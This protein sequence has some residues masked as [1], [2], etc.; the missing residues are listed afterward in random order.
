RAR[1]LEILRE[2]VR[3]HLRLERSDALRLIDVF[4]RLGIERKGAEDDHLRPREELARFAHCHL[5]LT[6]L[7]RGML[8]PEADHDALARLRDRT[9][10]VQITRP[11]QRLQIRE[12]QNLAPFASDARLD[13]LIAPGV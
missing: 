3:V 5:D 2:E 9:R 11:R 6:L 13:E 4:C 7:Q 8:R 1:L 12:L 10:A